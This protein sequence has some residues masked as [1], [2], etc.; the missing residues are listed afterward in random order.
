M[1]NA[2]EQSIKQK[3]ILIVF[4]KLRLFPSVEIGVFKSNRYNRTSLLE[5]PIFPAKNIKW[6]GALPIH[7][8]NL[9]GDCFNYRLSAFSGEIKAF[10]SKKPQKTGKKSNIST[11]KEQT[12]V[13]ATLS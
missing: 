6:L 3:L 13:E 9:R 5:N 12:Q 2:V 7:Q 8:P 1:S 10:F 4:E 11:F